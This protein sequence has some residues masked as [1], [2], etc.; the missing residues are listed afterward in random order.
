MVLVRVLGLA[1]ALTGLGCTAEPGPS[2]GA[3]KPNILFIIADDLGF[4]DLGVY[5]AEVETPVL[6]ALAA[7]GVQFT[8]FHTAATC[9]PSRSMLL[10]GVDNHR[11]GLGSMGEFLT[12]DQRGAPG[13]EGY[14]NDRVQTV[15]ERLSEAG[16]FTAFSG[17]WHLGMRPEQWPAARGF[18]RS[19]ALLDGSGDNWSDTGP[20]PIVPKTTFTRNGEQVERPPGFSS[21]LFVDELLAAL[22]ARGPEQPF[23][24]VLSFQ[25]VHWPHHAPEDV[26]A[27]YARRYDDGWDVMRQA[28]YERMVERGVIAPGVAERERD[29]NVPAWDSLTSAEQRRESARMAAYAAMTED[30]DREIGRVLAAF[31]AAGDLQETIV[32]FV[33]DNGPDLSEPNLAPRAVAWY[34]ER[35]PNQSTEALG[36]PGSFPS[37]GPQWAQLGA[38]H[39]RDYKGSAAEGGMRVPFIIRAPGQIDSGRVTP[40]FAFATDVVPTLLELTGV[41]ADPIAGHE[42]IDGA[43]MVPLL[44]GERERVHEPEAVIGYELMIGKAVFQ[45]DRKLV[46]VGSP[47]GDG[48]WRLFDI[49]KDPGE[50][51][52][53]READPEDFARMQGLFDGYVERY[54]VIPMDP[55]FDVFE[56]LTS[57]RRDAAHP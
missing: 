15:G 11:N 37:Y 1:F 40:A 6:D 54:G 46:Q 42:S 3:R 52:D 13:Y 34:D 7:E 26:L 38:V 50:Q 10:T 27:K 22:E 35:Y 30:M 29:P 9:S 17:K 36:G 8:S 2:E 12:P 4:G 47:A 44:R 19:F 39:L 57:A 18:A 49:V 33:S 14:L 5:G 48:V 28:R 55:D 31:E 41:S 32:V 23:L 24:A 45:G 56:A 20:A 16:Y 43:S 25:A 51:R 53:L 21:A